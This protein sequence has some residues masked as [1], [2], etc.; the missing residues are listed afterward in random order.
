MNS[1][2]RLLILAALAAP[3]VAQSTTGTRVARPI[4]PQSQA[5]IPAVDPA[6]SPAPVRPARDAAQGATSSARKPFEPATQRTPAPAIDRLHYSAESDGTQWVLGRT[7]KASFGRGGATY[8]PF[9]GSDAPRNFPLGLSLA[10]ASVDGVEIPL[11]PAASAVRDGDRVVIER[12]PIDEVYEIGLESVEQTFVVGERPASGDLELVVRLDSEMSRSERADGYVFS[13]EHGAV[14]YGRAFVR[15]ADGDRIPVSSRLVE[16]GVE[17]VVGRDYLAN[18]SFPLVVDPVVT[19]FPVD[20]IGAD[21]LDSDVAYDLTTDRYLVVYERAFS[22]TDGDIEVQE[23]DA[24]GNAIAVNFVD[25][26]AQNWRHPQTANLNGANQF[27]CVAQVS[28]F[29]GLPGWNIIGATIDAQTMVQSWPFVISTADQTGDKILADVGG[30]P[31]EGTG[32][33]CVTWHRTFTATD[34]DIHA[35]LV[36]SDATL[37]GPGTLLIDNSGSSKDTLP[38]ISKSNGTQGA[39][40]AWT[41]A[42]HRDMGA[43]N[44]DVRAAVLGWDGTLLNGSAVIANTLVPEYFP[45]V[46]SPLDDGRVLLVYAANFGDHDLVYALLNGTTIVDSG[47]LTNLDANETLFQDQVEFSVDSDGERFVVAYAESYNN[48]AFDYDIWVSSF[49]PFGTSLAV[50]E[51]HQSLDFSAQQ[52]LR[53]DVVAKRSGGAIGSKRCWVTWDTTTSDAN[54]D[55]LGGLYDIPTG[56]GSTP[57]CFGDGLGVACPCGN[58]GAFHQGCANSQNPLGAA[59]AVVGNAQTGAGDNLAFTVTGVPANVTC[60]LF[61]GTSDSGGT[62]FGDGVRCVSGTQIRIRTKFATGTTATW[63]SGAE[64]DVSVTGLIPLVGAQRYYQ[65]TYRNAAAFCT[66]A[67]FNLSNGMRVLWLP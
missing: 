31:F 19:T 63:P 28:G 41:I 11:A 34:T 51:A 53:T 58:S 30:D 67:T 40:A 27:L 4:Q 32:Y 64:P 8:V 3:A 42:W 52:A 43:G 23:R 45:C 16:G 36:A 44:Y 39:S 38:S 29:P 60:T 59:L 33:Y 24:A 5:K 6:P 10:S 66:S 55:I 20:T 54:H 62:L 17:I 57:F 49:A 1:S 61:Q 65:V 47:N 12:G 22:A 2:T 21:H 25:A 26:T 7:F 37:V 14:G 50:T 13:N 46:S 48:S 35:R 56:G 9:L 18:A 15:E